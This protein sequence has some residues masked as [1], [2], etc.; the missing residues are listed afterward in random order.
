MKRL[1]PYQLIITTI[2]SI[3]ALLLSTELLGFGHG[4]ND[5]SYITFIAALILT[6][7]GMLAIWTLAVQ[8]ERAHRRLEQQRQHLLGNLT[9][10]V[11]EFDND[12]TIRSWNAA[13]EKVYGWAAA[14]AIGQS[15]ET[16]LQT[17]TLNDT[18][19]QAIEAVRTQGHWQ[20]HFI[21]AKRGGALLHVQVNIV[22]RYDA[23]GQMDGY[24]G[25]MLETTE[26]HNTHQRLQK[27]VAQ[28]DALIANAQLAML[29]VDA[30][31][32]VEF[33]GGSDL[34]RFVNVPDPLGQLIH[35]ILGDDNKAQVLEH[36]SAAL[37][38]KST[39]N[40]IEIGDTLFDVRF[41]PI[42]MADGSVSHT[43][44]VATD[45]TDYQLT[46][47]MMQRYA[48][49]LETLREIDEA[50]LAA[51]NPE[52]IAQV[53][54]GYM[55]FL[56]PHTVGALCVRGP[57]DAWELAAFLD[58]LHRVEAVRLK[59]E[60]P[61]L[62]GDL[63]P[64]EATTV[65]V[66]LDTLDSPIARLFR[67]LDL[68]S[69]L[70]VP[71]VYRQAF[72]GVL[73]LALEDD[74]HLNNEQEQFL[75]EVAHTLAVALE[76]ANLNQ[77]V[78]LY[79]TTLEQDI[80]EVLNQE[81]ITQSSS[82]AIL[83]GITDAVIFTDAD[84]LIKRVN[85]ALTLIFGHTP[86]AVLGTQ[87]A[88]LACE[89]ERPRLQQAIEM[90]LATGTPQRVDLIMRNGAD[91]RIMVDVGVAPIKNIYS[92][93]D[94]LVLNLRDVTESRK[95]EQELRRNLEDAR[96]L[97]ELRSRFVSTVS[98][99]FRT[100]LTVIGSST[101][102][103]EMYAAATANEDIQRHVTRIQDSIQTMKVMLDDV[104]T[105]QKS[106]HERDIPFAPLDVVALT[107][108]VISNVQTA[109]RDARAIKLE[110]GGTPQII[111][112]NGNK[113]R[114]I[115]A[116]LITNAVKYSPQESTI[117]VNLTFDAQTLTFTVTNEGNPIPENELAHLFDPFYRASNAGTKQGTGLGL[118]IAK[119]AIDSHHG[120]VEVTSRSDSG[121]CFKV[122]L[123][124]H[125]NNTVTHQEGL[126]Q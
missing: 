123:P 55:P 61:N 58:S 94:G 37:A 49:R 50:V 73:L 124:I 125:H 14:E 71:L 7:G 75:Q 107:Q 33:A 93:T 102:L 36:V 24:T 85:P 10:A 99:E 4:S 11:I 47:A 16:L 19:P 44:V 12:Y 1:R 84:G 66:A 2:L 57:H 31:F 29:V 77:Q 126:S 42:Y 81:H 114:H 86:E 74:T 119:E 87:V 96:R 43:A 21:Q 39:T 48:I 62:L 72:V 100:P 101:E 28:L 53:A 70:I 60:W 67:G 95:N 54:L 64:R 122:Q 80:I 8:Q 17:P 108:N 30:H 118:S 112:A 90:A 113:V 32:R 88:N 23:Q 34:N 18:Y 78:R 5:Q 115:I 106:Q 98:H 51:A 20:G 91:E 38:R 68:N 82:E 40:I 83:D 121:T 63:T 120:T 92:S 110:V 59:D 6:L 27:N 105:L 3:D 69:V 104:V 65:T 13:A 45:I 79:A 15:G 109:A 26:Q 35:S 103:I 116:N 25:L 117:H 46:D 97:S 9:E 76:H 52:G 111:S 89:L 56:L 22:A 41:S